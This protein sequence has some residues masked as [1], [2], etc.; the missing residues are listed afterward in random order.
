MSGKDRASGNRRSRAPSVRTALPIIPIATRE[1]MAVL[2]AKHGRLL[3]EYARHYLGKDGTE[4]EVEEV[5]GRTV[6]AMLDAEFQPQP[7]GLRHVTQQ[8]WRE[9]QREMELRGRR[10][11]PVDKYLGALTGQVA[12]VLEQ[13]GPRSRQTILRAAQGWT[14]LEQAKADNTSVETIHVRLHRARRRAQELLKDAGNSTSALVL[15]ASARVRRAGHRVAVWCH[16]RIPGINWPACGDPVLQ[17]A[18]ITVIAVGGVAATGGPAPTTPRSSVAFVLHPQTGVPSPALRPTA[19]SDTMAVQSA[20]PPSHG[21]ADPN[22]LGAL[23]PANTE[24]HLLANLAPDGETPEDAQLMTAAAPADYASTHTIV[25]LGM[26]HRCVCPVL[27]QSTDGGANW[28]ASKAAAP[29]GA[30]QVALPPS[31]PADPRVFIGT[32]AQGGGSTY[33]AAHFGDVPTAM[34]GPA[35]HLALAAGFDHGDNRVFIAAQGAVVAVAVDATPPQIA[36]VLA[37]PQWFNPPATVATPAGSDGAAVVVLAPPE[38]FAIG[39]PLGGETQAPA[40]FACAAGTTCAER[41][42]APSQARDLTVSSSDAVSAVSWSNGI[43]VSQDG[44]HTFRVPAMPSPGVSL[45]SVA[46]T[47]SRVWAL[48]TQ[49]ATVTARWTSA[50]GGAWTDVTGSN[51]GLSRSLRIVA[52]PQGPLLDFLQGQGLRCTADGGATWADRCP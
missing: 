26:G 2:L 51:N 13:L 42:A 47:G 7:H 19:A 41:G 32:N 3:R 6:D 52:I 18:A 31:Y 34:P 8:V 17:L 11:Y 30:E 44:G 4:D 9:C 40:I 22:G 25:A 39:D 50:A 5:V 10:R 45:L 20:A 46:A 24:A 49:G 36:P 48:I 38:T 37:Y 27:F 29:S 43:A 33:V 15:V 1:D 28:T 12:R 16:R 21:R 35:G 14:P 23:A